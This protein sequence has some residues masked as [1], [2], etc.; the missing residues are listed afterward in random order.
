MAESKKSGAKKNSTKKNT[1]SKSKTNVKTSEKKEA[2]VKEEVEI[3][4]IKEVNPKKKKFLDNISLEQIVIFGF[5]IIAILLIVLIGVSAKNTKTSKGKDIVAKLSGKT[6]TADDLYS[7]LKS[8][9]GRAI[10]V[11][12]IDEYIL[13]KEYKTTSE[14]EKSAD[15]TISNYK[16]QY[17]DT[18]ESM[19]EYNGID[20]DKQLKE[21][22][23][24]NSKIK[25]AVEDY[26]KDNLTDSELKEYYDNNIVGDIKASHILIKF[27]YADDDTD[28]AKEEKKNNAK[29]KAEEIIEK[30]K[31]GE[32]FASLAKEYSEDTGSKENGGDL[33]YFNKGQMVAPF[34]EAAYKLK[35]D[36]YTKEPV[37]SEYGYHIILK[38]GEKEKPTLKKAKDSIIEKLVEQKQ[39]DD[40]TLDVKA[41]IALRKKYKLS[42]KDSV[43]KK[44][45]NSYNKKAITTTT[46]SSE[47]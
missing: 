46:T 37:E 38:T 4:E 5:V 11:N 18:Y 22:L 39:E 2:I 34:E 8:Q 42:I 29:A 30:I 26:I 27:N 36:E 31:N 14:M 40:T 9:N 47:S 19:L 21:L 41:M 35:V 23:I 17:G 15:S 10:L 28:E 12:L 33:G 25:L 13:D 44:E 6:I 32:D 3:K 1:S 45:Y 24:K 43:I 7:E 16:S 20:G